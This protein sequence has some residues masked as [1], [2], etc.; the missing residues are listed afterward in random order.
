MLRAQGLGITMNSP[1]IVL[2]TMVK[3]ESRIIE[4]LLNSVK[5]VSDAV[6]VCDTGSTDSTVALATAW[7]AGAKLPG[8]IA[9]FPFT[10]FGKSRTRS[11]E[12]CQ[13]WVKEVGWCA[14]DTWALVIDG[15]MLLSGAV[16]RAAL[17]GLA[18]TVAG[19]SLKQSAG[20]LVY[21][22]MRLMRVSEPWICKGATHEAW[23]CPGGRT[24][25]AFDM[26]VILDR[27][28][29][30]CKADKYPR[31]VRLL[32]EDLA[33]MPED[34]RTW[35]YLGQTYQC[36]QDWG[37]GVEALKKRISLGG[38]EE[39]VYIARVYLGECYEGLGARA[40]AIATYMDAWCARPVRTEAPMHLITLYRKEKSS[41]MLAGL[42]LERLF[43]EVMGEDLR[44]GAVL[45]AAATCKDILFVNQRNMDYHLW[46]ELAIL[47]FY[48][49]LRAHAW[50]QLDML[51]LT[52]LLPW[53]DANRLWGHM[54]WY[55]WVV[56]GEKTRFTVGAPFADGSIWQPFNPSIVQKD[57]GYIV[58]LR[59]ANYYTNDA[60][61]YQYRGFAGQVI[62]RNCLLE[63]GGAWNSPSAVREIMIDRAE[64]NEVVRG[65][66]DCRLIS[67]EEWFAT[68][69]SYA[70]T[71][72]NKIFHGQRSGLGERSDLWKITQMPLP[73]GVPSSECQKNWLPFRISGEL[74][75]IYS[76][77]PFKICDAGGAVKV[78]VDTR[79]GDLMLKEYR[80]SAGPVE[81]TSGA[82]GTASAAGPD[83]AY[84][85]V[86]HKVQYAENGRRYYHRFMT[87]DKDF[88]P[89]RVS[90][91]VRMSREQIEYWSG[92]CL[93][94]D[95]YL[96][97]YGLKD[98]E[99]WI[100]TVS[101]EFVEGS[102][103]YNLKT[104]A[105][106]PYAERLRWLQAQQLMK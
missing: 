22:N 102:L 13:A 85:C 95:G 32:R 62:T 94:P 89:S 1:R 97:T 36:M 75:Y 70:D 60:K 98:S 56:G 23:T 5:E 104:G 52:T 28:D 48:T 35:F 34:A 58:N 54:H 74:H 24:T 20:S 17:G 31:D 53:T 105:V 68:S 84:L 87:L 41:Q 18:A 69:K 16:D 65:I 106:R 50:L 2:L 33:A 27:G 81:W 25:V 40:E 30:G 91:F 57:T 9:E 92:M 86:M 80:G 46:E 7:L 61:V 88:R 15:D 3:N 59:Y 93:G 103:M 67:P 4:R 99:A 100:A 83:E 39:E 96:I 42:V 90:C 11:Y 77:S 8:K 66:E 44:T 29:G 63:V 47:G 45:G 49:G 6:I 64:K 73:P 76:F 72:T 43:G 26:P 21:A 19:V 10:N 55:D 37:G 14:T 71:D 12:I 79:V 101:K 82:A 38:W 51:D 78:E